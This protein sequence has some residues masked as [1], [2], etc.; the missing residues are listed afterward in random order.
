[1]VPNKTQDRATAVVTGEAT[2]KFRLPGAASNFTAEAFYLLKAVE[3]VADNQQT[4]QHHLY[5]LD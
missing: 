3:I 5:R 1:M 4:R 2:Y